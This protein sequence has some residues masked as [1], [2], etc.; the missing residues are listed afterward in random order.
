MTL[1]KTVTPSIWKKSKT[2]AVLLAVFLGPWTWIYTIKKDAWKAAAALGVSLTL[3]VI[4]IIFWIGISSMEVPENTFVD[5]PPIHFFL[6]F[7]FVTSVF[8]TWLWALIDT[9][10]KRK[11]YY[12]TSS[13]EVNKVIAVI[14]AG[15]LGPWTWLYTYQKDY[16]KFWVS[17]LLVT[18][19]GIYLAVINFAGVIAITALAAFIIWLIALISAAKRPS[20]FYNS[21]SIPSPTPT[22]SR[23]RCPAAFQR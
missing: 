15:F 7:L 18:G 22:S 23:Q 21:L 8:I 13:R 19:G 6:G 16:L 17:I 10:S 14:F 4:T 20:S 2:I 11:E 9:L 1:A 5:M 12:H 3:L